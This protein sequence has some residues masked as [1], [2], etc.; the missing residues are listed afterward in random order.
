MPFSWVFMLIICSYFTLIT[1]Y[2]IKYLFNGTAFIFDGV[3]ILLGNSE[4]S[5]ELNEVTKI[6]K[7]IGIHWSYAIRF[8]VK[9]LKPFSIKYL[10]FALHG[11]SKYIVLN[12]IFIEGGFER[13]DDLYED[14][15]VALEK[16]QNKGKSAI[17]HIP[18]PKT[19]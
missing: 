1:F 19:L 12:S 15:V 13:F 8:T 7:I 9:Q 16:C 6:E 14:L 4:Y 2:S 10:P 17:P 5:F 18:R 3:S 11:R